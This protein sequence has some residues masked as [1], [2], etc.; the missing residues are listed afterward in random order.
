MPER[1]YLIYKILGNW[2]NYSIFEN[3][4]VQNDQKTYINLGSELALKMAR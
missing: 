3:I 2:V 4:G 1:K